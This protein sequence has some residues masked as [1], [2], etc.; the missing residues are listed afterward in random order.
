MSCHDQPMANEAPG[1]A[2]AIDNVTFGCAPHR[3]L[4]ANLMVGLIGAV[5]GNAVLFVIFG[6]SSGRMP[7]PNATPWLLT[8]GLV[9]AAGFAGFSLLFMRGRPPWVRV[10]PAGVELAASRTDPVLI[11]WPA[12]SLARFRWRGPL[13]VLEITPSDL[14]A[15]AMGQRGGRRP[16]PRRRA[17]RVSFVVDVGALRAGPTAIRAELRRR[18]CPVLD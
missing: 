12:V 7:G 2:A 10:G 4:V 5:I 14:A 6:L 13:T 3:L 17:G 8:Y 16:R 1:P 18:G 11:P 15:V 9:Y